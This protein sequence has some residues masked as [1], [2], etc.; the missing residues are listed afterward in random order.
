VIRWV[1]LGIAVI[2]IFLA[3]V[4]VLGG[5]A[6]S[7]ATWPHGGEK[8][9]LVYLVGC[10]AVLSIPTVLFLTTAVVGLF[11]VGKPKDD[12][13]EQRVHDIQSS[14]DATADLV[15]ELEQE[16]TERSAALKAL[17]EQKEEYENLAA[18]NREEA[19]AVSRLVDKAVGHAGRKSTRVGYL[20]FGLGVLASIPL[21]VLAIWIAS[22]V[23]G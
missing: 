2:V 17:V 18:L 12:S 11:Q 5:W 21:G 3:A 16:L 14:L 10:L 1:A 8:E 6:S 4:G 9:I 13:I 23:H 15:N 22:L 20:L 7:V 19:E